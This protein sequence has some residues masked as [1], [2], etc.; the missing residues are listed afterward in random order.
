MSQ[1]IKAG[2]D[3]VNINGINARQAIAGV[4]AERWWP[5]GAQRPY[6]TQVEGIRE[7]QYRLIRQNNRLLATLP[8][9]VGG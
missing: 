4:L 1:S 2:L 9:S 6:S 8:A 5:A 3:S 7:Q